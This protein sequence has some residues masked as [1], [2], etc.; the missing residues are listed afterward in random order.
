MT[1]TAPA[2]TPAARADAAV[3]E[4]LQT[5]WDDLAALRQRRDVAQR[6]RLHQ[7]V[8][9]RRRLDR[10]RDDAFARGVGGELAEQRVLRAAAGDV[11]GA[12]LIA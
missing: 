1:M 8:P 10:P 12:E 11:D 6:Q 5:Q 2:L 9:Q 4:I 7:D 3:R